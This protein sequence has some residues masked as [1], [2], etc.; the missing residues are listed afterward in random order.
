MSKSPNLLFVCPE[1]SVSDR[2]SNMSIL[3]PNC[4][5]FLNCRVNSFCSVESW[6]TFLWNI[7]CL[8]VLWYWHW[9]I[10]VRKATR[11]KRVARARKKRTCSVPNMVLARATPRVYFVNKKFFR[12]CFTKFQVW[13][14]RYPKG[15]S[16][17]DQTRRNFRNRSSVTTSNG[18]PGAAKMC[19]VSVLYITNIFSASSALKQIV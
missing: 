10:V 12:A 4:I 19:R 6:E 16:N 2:V 13:L 1:C 8:A 15:K 18:D 5:S 11:A 3:A 9:Y 17:L 7:H 14:Q